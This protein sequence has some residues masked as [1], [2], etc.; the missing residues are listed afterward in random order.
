MKNVNAPAV[1][2]VIVLALGGMQAGASA[3]EIKALA[4]IALQSVMEDLGAAIREGK[5]PQGE[6]H[7]RS[8]R[9]FGEASARGRGRRFTVRASRQCRRLIKAGRL[10]PSSDT[11]LARSSVGA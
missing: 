3:A 6:H 10:E 9:P 11:N 4:T 7:I 8:R 1:F 2:A 5:R